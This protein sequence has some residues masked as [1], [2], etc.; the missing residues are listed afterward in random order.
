MTYP[1]IILGFVI[2]SFIGALAHL[3][4]GGNAGRFLVYIIASW[5]GFWI[6]HIVGARTDL[7]FLR[8]GQLNL[9]MALI[10]AL[11][12]VVLGHWLSLVEGGNETDN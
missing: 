9:G 8:L 3:W 2:S 10:G 4:R 1:A 5:A 7:T 6:G 12:F 11:L